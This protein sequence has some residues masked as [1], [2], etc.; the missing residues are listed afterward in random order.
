MAR[1]KSRVGAGGGR[2]WS[3]RV[4]LIAFALVLIV[5]IAALSGLAIARFAGSEQKIAE[6]QAIAAAREAMA[7]TD[8]E[9]AND[10]AILDTLATSL[11]LDTGDYPSFQRLATRAVR[12]RSAHVLLLRPDLQQLVNTRVPNGTALPATADPVTAGKVIETHRPQVSDLFVGAIAEHYVFNIEVPVLREGQ[13][14]YILIM[15]VEPMRILDI[16]KAQAMPPGWAFTVVDR[17]RRVIARTIEPAEFLGRQGRRGAESLF[18][19]RRTG[20][21]HAT[22]FEGTPIIGAFATSELTGWTFSAWVSTEILEGPLRR[23]WLIFGI[24]VG[25]LLVVSLIAAIVFGRMMARPMDAVRR[26]AVAL[27]HGEP[28]PER[29]FG[30]REANE[31]SAAFRA[32]ALE[33][34]AQEKHLQLLVGELSHR[35]KNQL[36]VMQ[37]LVRQTKIRSQSL[38][39]FETRFSGRLLGLGRSIDL[40]VRGDWRG[41]ALGDLAAAQ[42]SPFAEPGGGRLELA[43][44]EVRLRP[45]ATQQIG[46]AL[47]ELATNST[48]YGAL[49]VP[50]GR[51]CVGWELCPDEG[52]PQSVRITWTES[53]GPRVEAPPTERGFGRLVIE[54]AVAS[55]LQAD[56]SVEFAPEGMRWSLTLPASFL[57][58]SPDTEAFGGQP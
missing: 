11:Y 35:T 7:D 39:D 15:T 54:Q 23:S 31:L 48:K 53:G 13:L 3:L 52:A 2:A 25:A 12:T 38:D 30:L 5:P 41:A 14:A 19:N 9:L 46:M 58:G 47:H 34:H 8:R 40:L 33:R 26:D 17:D 57:V 36:A 18:G 16:V 6:S 43:G 44:P 29:R 32:A 22:N 27:G 56:V 10:I 4:H 49:S 45:E 42:L 21:F 55:N 50:H 28:V 1:D 24:G 51:V 20:V 37:A